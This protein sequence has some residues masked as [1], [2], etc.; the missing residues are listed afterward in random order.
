MSNVRPREGGQQAVQDLTGTVLIVDGDVAG[1]EGLKG[2]L[3]KLGFEVEQVKS[4]REA[5]LALEA[6]NF[7]SDNRRS[8]VAR[9]F[10]AGAARGGER[11]R[12]RNSRGSRCGERD[13]FRSRWTRCGAVR[14]TSS[15]SPFRTKR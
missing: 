10:G 6:R 14:R 15:R 9:P 4:G 8:P 12:R 11:A 7:D 5:V 1:A 13:R 2:F 3:L